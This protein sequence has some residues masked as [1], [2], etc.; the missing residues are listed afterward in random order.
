MNSLFFPIFNTC[1]HILLR[2]GAS[3]FITLISEILMFAE[4]LSENCIGSSA[5]VGPFDVRC[6]SSF[7]CVFSFLVLVPSKCKMLRFTSIFVIIN[8]SFS[9]F[10]ALATY[11]LCYSNEIE[12]V[13]FMFQHRHLMPLIQ[14]LI[15]STTKCYWALN[16]GGV[17]DINYH[18]N[19]WL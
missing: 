16:I 2:C 8:V 17:C 9:S 12:I 11:N 18:V 10:C 6:I 3:V 15:K 19:I 13:K 5:R 14:V 4:H 1:I 7:I